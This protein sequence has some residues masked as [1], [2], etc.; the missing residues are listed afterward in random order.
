MTEPVI[1]APYWSLLFELMCDASDHA[2]GAVL[3][4]IFRHS[5]ECLHSSRST[6]RMGEIQIPVDSEIEKTLYRRLREQRKRMSKID[7][8]RVENERVNGQD[9]P[10]CQPENQNRLNV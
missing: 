3:Y 8:G 4:L 7:D 5:C 9:P 1:I 6:R 2:I 10:A